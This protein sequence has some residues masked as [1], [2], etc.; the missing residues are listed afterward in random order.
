LA[1]H[2]PKMANL[3]FDAAIAATAGALR[4]H[5]FGVPSDID[6]RATSKKKPGVDFRPYPILGASNP[7]MV[8]RALQAEEKIGTM[9]PC[10]VIVQQL[11]RGQVEVSAVDPVSSM[12]A[13]DTPALAGTANKVHDILRRVAEEIGATTR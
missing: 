11:E 6:V 1:Y 10:N 5:G 2:F 4:H 7:Q 3:P 8:Y 12:Q 9:L 13:V